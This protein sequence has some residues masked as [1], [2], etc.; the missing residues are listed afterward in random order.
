[1]QEQVTIKRSNG[2]WTVAPPAEIPVTFVFIE[3]DRLP[4]TLLVDTATREQIA[5]DWRIG[6]PTTSYQYRRVSDRSEATFMVR[7]SDV[8]YVC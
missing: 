1:M 2:E 4:V 5:T 8:L 7:F 6:H 3:P